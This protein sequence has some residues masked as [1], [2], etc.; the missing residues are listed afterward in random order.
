MSATGAE[1]EPLDHV[2]VNVLHDMDAAAG[3]FTALG[4]TLTPRGH[5][6]LGS[7]NHLMVVPGAYLEL[8]GLPAEGRQRAEVRDS[9]RGLNGLVLRS[10]DA[11]AT[12][13]RLAQA[14]LAPLDVVS[15][16]RPVEVDGE[17]TAAASRT[18][19]V[20]D[21][22]FPAG[23]VYFC[24]H[25]TPDL[26][27]RPDWMRHD[28]GFAGFAHFTIESPDPARDSAIYAA[29]TA[30]TRRETDVILPD[31]LEIRLRSGPRPR[32]A[33]LGLRFDT[34]APLAERAAALDGVEWQEV[35]AT[36]ALLDLP[37]CDLRIECYTTTDPDGD[38][39]S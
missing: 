26:V 21:A 18:V 25:L 33:A 23:R 22:L 37:S 19:R 39:C 28:N 15:F 36:Q 10:A 1:G 29:A 38:V 3:L 12:H 27:W 5:H 32:F 20:P 13:A 14:E 34:L 31:G 8:V 16:S 24:Q 4:F 17:Q 7:I 9:P 6:S 35:S 2:V 11:D 30:G